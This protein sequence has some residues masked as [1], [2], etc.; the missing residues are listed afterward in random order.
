MTNERHT[1]SFDEF[2][3]EEKLT[4]KRRYTDKYPKM[5]ISS[6]APIREKILSFVKESGEVTHEEL[7]EF[8]AGMNEETGGATSRKWIN[9]NTRYFKISE[10]NGSKTY[11]LSGLGSRVHSAIMNQIS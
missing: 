6:V 11:R 4:I 5:E 1:L 7:M 9:K 10:K 8:I 3:N 2:I